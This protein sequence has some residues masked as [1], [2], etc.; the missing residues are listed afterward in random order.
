[1]FH[2][3]NLRSVLLVV[4]RNEDERE[5]ALVGVKDFPGRIEV[6]RSR[7]LAY[8]WLKK[9]DRAKVAVLLAHVSSSS[10]SNLGSLLRPH[11]RRHHVPMAFARGR[12]TDPSVWKRGLRGIKPACTLTG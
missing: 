11:C 12:V 8:S 10:D 5:A 2:E 7:E 4:A 6:V 9:G 1:M 3:L